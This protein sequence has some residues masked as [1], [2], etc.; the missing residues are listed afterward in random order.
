MAG[1]QLD[2]YRTLQATRENPARMAGMANRMKSISEDTR[3]A[4]R[5]LARSCRTPA[6]FLRMSDALTKMIERSGFSASCDPRKAREFQLLAV[7]KDQLSSRQLSESLD[8]FRGIEGLPQEAKDNML[9]LA[10]EISASRGFGFVA[11]SLTLINPSRDSI[12]NMP[13]TNKGPELALA[14]QPAYSAPSSQL[15]MQS[16]SSASFSTSPSSDLTHFV[17][18]REA[19]F[20]ISEDIHRG[21]T[22]LERAALMMD[23]KDEPMVVKET[24]TAPHPLSISKAFERPEE[25]KVSVE[26]LPLSNNAQATSE[27]SPIQVAQPFEFKPGSVNLPPKSDDNDDFPPSPSPMH[28]KL[29][30]SQPRIKTIHLQLPKIKLIQNPETCVQPVHKAKQVRKMAQEKQKSEKTTTLPINEA[31]KPKQ[32]IRAMKASKGHELVRVLAHKL[33]SHWQDER[34]H[35]VASHSAPAAKV[36]KAPARQEKRTEEHKITKKKS[37]SKKAAKRRRER[38]KFREKR[39]KQKMAVRELLK[40]RKKNKSRRS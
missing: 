32:K 17:M 2:V 26:S 34:G 11:P 36:Q 30:P 19:I 14:F 3:G 7:F 20:R 24:I 38:G 8:R 29:K 16:G 31:K 25:S 13:L 15:S 10:T 12:R 28:K 37:G 40:K 27:A 39:K 23:R 35:P 22:S 4:M 1:P 33:R 6:E 5:E 18:A 21:L 9:Q